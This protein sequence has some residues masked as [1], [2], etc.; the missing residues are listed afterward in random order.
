[1]DKILQKL[2]K[3][4]LKFKDRLHQITGKLKCYLKNFLKVSICK[5]IL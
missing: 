4:S 3:Y 5:M 1:M 2:L